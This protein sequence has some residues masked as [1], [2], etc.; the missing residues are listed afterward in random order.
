M[1]KES[2]ELCGHR[3]EVYKSP[4]AFKNSLGE[5]QVDE[6]VENGGENKQEEW[7]VKQE[8][9]RQES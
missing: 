9:Q 1:C 6:G 8:A 7:C 5:G 2:N 4:E 3:V